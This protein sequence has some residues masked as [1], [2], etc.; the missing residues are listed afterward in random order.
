MMTQSTSSITTPLHPRVQEQ[1]Q[2][3]AMSD[4]STAT[5]SA[6]N[7]SSTS[8]AS[9]VSVTNDCHRQRKIRQ[10]LG[11]RPSTKRSA[12]SLLLRRPLT[13][14]GRSTTFPITTSELK[15]TKS[16]AKL[17]EMRSAIMG[18]PTAPLRAISSHTLKALGVRRRSSATKTFDQDPEFFSMINFD[19]TD[20]QDRANYDDIA[21]K[22]YIRR[23]P[24]ALKAKYDFPVGGRSR[25]TISR[26]PLS[27]LVA[28]GASLSTVKLAIKANHSALQ[29]SL[30]FQSTV[31]H[32]ACS[33]APTNMDVVRYIYNKYPAAIRATTK[34]V[35]LPLHNAC[36]A[37]QPNLELVQFL[38]E[39]HPDALMAI[40]KLGDTPL[41]TA[42]RNKDMQPEVLEFLNG[43]TSQVFSLEENSEIY[44]RV[45]TRQ[46]WGRQ[47]FSELARVATCATEA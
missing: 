9:P 38:V 30:D 40:N 41:R 23:C 2:V 36:Q 4:D 10:S 8:P 47:D 17:E 18:K 3:Q 43:E 29:A 22:K 14:N 24:E 37:K 44:E 15:I 11:G 12:S 21:V 27:T 31:L 28:L 42:Q 5:A 35:F 46:S 26:Y 16:C 6:L 33:S 34:L 1:E 25:L 20:A 13:R 32:T 45:Q 19:L 39:E 7:N